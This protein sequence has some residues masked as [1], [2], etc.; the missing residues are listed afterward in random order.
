VGCACA[1]RGLR[2]GS[3]AH[4]PHRVCTDTVCACRIQHD[5]GKEETLLQ[6]LQFERDLTGV[7]PLQCSGLV[8]VHF[9][10]VCPVRLIASGPRTVFKVLTQLC[11]PCG[12]LA[13]SQYT[14]SSWR[15]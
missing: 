11:M 7:W 12:A 9:L 2:C 1:A 10:R 3:R 6:Q 14:G 8:C 5:L 15:L 4:A 13:R